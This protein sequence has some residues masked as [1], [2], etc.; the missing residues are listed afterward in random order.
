MSMKED[1]DVL[2][3]FRES[4]SNVNGHFHV[5]EQKVPLEKQMDY[6][7]N[8]ERFR[9]NNPNFAVSFDDAYAQECNLKLQEPTTTIE[10]MKRVLTEMAVSKNIK[11]FRILEEYAKNPRQDVADWTYM[12]LMECRISLESDFSDEKQIYI[13]TGLGGKV[14]KLRFYIFLLSR[15]KEPFLEYQRQIIEREF[16]YAL[17][18]A[19]CEIERLTIGEQYVELL[20]LISVRTDLK[21]IIDSIINEC[22]QY[23]NFLSN[24]FTVTNVKE[25]SEEEIQ[26]MIDKKDGDSKTGD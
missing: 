23:G 21:L 8:S 14:E 1:G 2:K 4:F 12:A 19:D 3:R 11:A 20:F 6:F 5:L 22:N 26:N 15:E 24:T 7:R 18:K 9:R 13:S 16:T 25:F 10:E 17:S